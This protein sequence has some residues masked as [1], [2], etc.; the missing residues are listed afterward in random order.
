MKQLSWFTVLI[1]RS[2][3]RRRKAVSLIAIFVFGAAGWS[4]G[5]H[6]KSEDEK[7]S[8]DLRSTLDSPVTPK[9]R[10][11]R[12]VGGTRHV[13]VIVI[14]NSADAELADLRA[15]VTS[16]GGSVQVRHAGIRGLTAIVPAS[17]VN[18]LAQR[19]DVASVVPNRETR[20]TASMVES[21]SGATT[22][23][24][25]TYSAAGSY[26]GLDGNGIGIAV[27]DSGVMRSHDAFQLQTGSAAIR[28]RRNVNMLNASLANWTT[29]AAAGSLQPGSAALAT[30]ENAIAND[31]A[32]TH[33]AYGHGTHVAAVAAGGYYA[34][35]SAAAKD[36]TGMAPGANIIDVKVLDGYGVGTLSDVLEGIQWVIYHAKEY[37]IRVLN[38]SLA[39]ASTQTW[40]TDPLCIAVR[41]ATAAGITVVVAGGNFG[42]TGQG[43]EAY[44]AIS[45]PGN[46]PTAI[47][48]GAVNFH[49]TTARGDDSVNLFSSRGPTR[50][51]YTDT[52]GVRRVDNLLK[53]DLV[54]P[55]NKIVGAAA[56]AS[57]GLSWDFLASFYNGQLVAPLGITPTL[58]ETQMMLSGTSIAAPAVAGAVALMLQANPGLTPPLIK[59]ILQY[60]AQ[61][62]PGQN[63]LQQGAGY[64]NVDGAV[65]LAKVLRTDLNTA[66]NAGSIAAGSAMLASG[67]TMPAR[68]S[69]I[70]GTAFNWSRIAFVGGNHVVSGDALFTKYQPIWDPRITWANGVVRQRVPGYWSGSGIAANTYVKNFTDVALTNQTLL[71]SGVVSANSLLGTSSLIGKTGVFTLTPTLSSWLVSGSGMTLASGIAL[72]SGLILSEGLVMSEGLVLSE[73]LVMSEGLVLSE[74][75]ILSEGMVLSET[76]AS[77]IQFNTSGAL[78]GER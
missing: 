59:A 30:Y 75:M 5:A 22:A 60:T 18:A 19:S 49:D 21:I 3:L 35:N 55:G 66:I 73:G 43:K 15:F 64:L 71:S 77:S 45:A 47:T 78:A 37:N 13:Q 40:Q 53:P 39:A 17:A 56:T 26:S 6:A 11:V 51:A 23:N 8:K 32:I 16:I 72:G 2:A 31:G 41:S 12:D 34:A 4:H 76:G 1:E 38:L 65:A 61:P 50:G 67:K 29:G 7:I 62:L 48:V 28:V 68:S 54:A 25:R 42:L 46:D 36:I 52:G 57:D 70:N 20:S 24:V 33:D 9:G 10:H 69:T 74:G 63:L 14:A 58:A 27:L 44:G